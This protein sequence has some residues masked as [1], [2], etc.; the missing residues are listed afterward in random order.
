LLPFGTW[1]MFWRCIL[2]VG[3]RKM[4][5]PTW[6]IFIPK[7][8]AAG[9]CSAP[10]YVSHTSSSPACWWIG[11]RYWVHVPVGVDDI[12]GCCRGINLLWRP[13]EEST[14]SFAKPKDSVA[15]IFATQ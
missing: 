14:E 13:G 10:W 5:W 3:D 8:F 12:G 1:R 7:P 11:Q 2:L 9:T 6:L 4:L 15:T